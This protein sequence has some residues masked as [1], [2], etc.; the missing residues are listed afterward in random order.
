MRSTGVAHAYLDRAP[1]IH[2]TAQKP[3]ALLPDY[4][5]QVLD[6]HALYRPITKGTFHLTAANAATTI[7]EAIALTQS[8]RPG[9]VHLQV[10]NEEAAQGL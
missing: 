9:P 3:D 7:A 6:L 4:T 1:V 8:G 2:I 10:S 5:H